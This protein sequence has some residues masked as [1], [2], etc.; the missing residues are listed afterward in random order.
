MREYITKKVFAPKFLSLFASGALASVYGLI[1]NFLNEGKLPMTFTYVIVGI[2]SVIISLIVS[3][4]LATNPDGKERQLKYKNI[5][6]RPFLM[7][8]F[9]AIEITLSVLFIKDLYDKIIE[10]NARIAT[11]PQ[12]QKIS[13]QN[14]G[15]QLPFILLIQNT[16]I[17]VLSSL[18]G[19]F[20]LCKPG[21][22]KCACGC[23][24]CWEK[25]GSKDFKSRWE[26][27]YK[28]KDHYHSGD[29]VGEVYS[30]ST[31]I[32]DVYGGSYHTSTEYER[33]VHYSSETEIYRCVW[34]GKIKEQRV[35]KVYKSP[36]E[37]KS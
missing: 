12:H 24:D 9:L 34:C 22:E 4:F 7:L 3:I 29:K 13:D 35:N 21:T 23:Y 1:L 16:A 10:L 31:K 19:F 37:Y 5:W 6:Y 25:I 33:S 17:T 11:E 14:F 15:Y 36:W 26:K 2:V 27:E 20:R 28:T 30:G 8:I 32:G 18:F